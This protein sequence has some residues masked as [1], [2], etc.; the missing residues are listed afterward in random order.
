MATCE[1]QA[2]GQLS[3]PVALVQ[4]SAIM[5]NSLGRCRASLSAYLA[6]DAATVAGVQKTMRI[7]SLLERM[8]ARSKWQRFSD[9]DGHALASMNM[10]E[11]LP[12]A[13]PIPF[14]LHVQYVIFPSLARAC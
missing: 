8:D 11:L 9:R 14:L 5:S 13:V 10:Q 1:T 2:A 4:D 12:G 7:I 6:V 3:A